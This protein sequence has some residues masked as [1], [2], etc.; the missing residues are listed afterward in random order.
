MSDSRRRSSAKS[1]KSDKQVPGLYPEK[2]REKIADATFHQ[3]PERV[4]TPTDA[5][6]TYHLDAT[7]RTG[8]STTVSSCFWQCVKEEIG[9]SEIELEQLAQ[10]HLHETYTPC[11]HTRISW[12]TY[13]PHALLAF[14]EEQ[15]VQ[16]ALG[17]AIAD[18]RRRINTNTPEVMLRGADLLN[19]SSEVDLEAGVP[20]K[21]TD[22]KVLDLETQRQIIKL[23]QVLTSHIAHNVKAGPLWASLATQVE[24]R[25]RI[26]EYLEVLSLFRDNLSFRSTFAHGVHDYNENK[27]HSILR[28]K[29]G[30]LRRKVTPTAV[31]EMV[32]NLHLQKRGVA[33]M[34]ASLGVSFPNLQTLSLSGN[35]IEVLENAP[36]NLLALHACGNEAKRLEPS[37]VPEPLIHLGV[38]YNCITDVSA[39]ACSPKLS[40]LDIAYNHI[41][42]FAALSPL[43]DHPTLQTVSLA[44]N[45]IML[46]PFGRQ[47]VLQA[48][49][50]IA[51]LD[52]IA[53][54][55]DE[56]NALKEMV[57]ANTADYE[58]ITAF[59]VKLVIEEIRGMK[60]VKEENA[61]EQKGATGKA[62]GKPPPKAAKG[63]PVKED[64]AETSTAEVTK[65]LYL[66]SR[67][68]VDVLSLRTN[69][70]TRDAEQ[71]NEPIRVDSET[72]FTIH[73]D[74]T[75]GTWLN[76]L[77]CIELRE[78]EREGEELLSDTLIGVAHVEM[79]RLLQASEEQA[80]VDVPLK[81]AT[82]FTLPLLPNSNMEYA[83]R[84]ALKRAAS[85]EACIAAAMVVFMLS[86]VVSGVDCP[87]SPK[88]GGKPVPADAKGGLAPAAAQRKPS[89]A[90][91]DMPVVAREEEKITLACTLHLNHVTP[92][93]PPPE[94]VVEKKGKR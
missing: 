46:L 24:L 50:N 83:K 21:T 70:I 42:S 66:T 28:K 60:E 27:K 52:S 82:S 80:S 63:K 76:S 93:P 92:P 4:S 14:A 7:Q 73:P 61:E 40:S 87:K 43:A 89:T 20:T 39:I 19:I 45:P 69:D 75:T 3:W 86:A 6:K 48:L 59:T 34:D 33:T 5:A 88:A 11:D 31:R 74:A 85:G 81:W 13:D 62:A 58:D 36:K 38:A 57:I 23:K 26:A 8:T 2:L 51:S 12:G 64:Q 55:A 91:S 79:W 84:R 72:T 71:A 44:G 9:F 37:A 35:C 22:A 94:P 49:P 78:A 90:Q 32:R 1:A 10:T 53:H 54:T 17:K 47:Q 30:T 41:H 67:G 56:R 18:L 15:G 16:N 29:E 25:T 77:Y 68:Q 65:R